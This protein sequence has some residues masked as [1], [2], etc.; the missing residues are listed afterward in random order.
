MRV[1][2]VICGPLEKTS[3]YPHRRRLSVKGTGAR[4]PFPW[5]LDRMIAY[6]VLSTLSSSSPF[7]QTANC[8]YYCVTSC[9]ATH[10][11]LCLDLSGGFIK[12]DRFSYHTGR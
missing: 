1:G 7:L 4:F 10:R 8:Q 5:S 3:S 12:P 6:L 9:I 11:C 2:Y